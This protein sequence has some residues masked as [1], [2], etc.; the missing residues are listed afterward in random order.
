MVAQKEGKSASMHDSRILWPTGSV[1]E[2]VATDGDY[3]ELWHLH[4][5]TMRHY[6]AATYGWVDAVQERLFREAWQWKVGQQVLVDEGVIVG[7]WLVMR[8]PEDLLVAFIRVAS[9][10][11][12]RGIGTVVLRR[13]LHDAAALR[14][15][16]RLEVMKANPDAERLYGRLGF[17]VEGNSPTHFRMMARS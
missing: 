13:I 8:R 2:R 3:D 6:V 12:R 9:S 7:N 1:T 16:A 11:Q 17:V 5:D 10:H 14:I 15:P 4:V